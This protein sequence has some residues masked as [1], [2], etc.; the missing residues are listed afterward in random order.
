MRKVL[1]ALTVLF[2]AGPAQADSTT[3]AS[4][5]IFSAGQ[6]SAVCYIAN[7]GPGAV[8]VSNVAI[9]NQN[10]VAQ[11]LI[12]NTCGVALAGNGKVCDFFSAIPANNAFSCSVSVDPSAQFVRGG[13]ELRTATQKSLAN[14]TLQ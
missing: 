11:V 13:F 4:G 12:G 14:A 5:P 2:W 7:F 3:L 8:T 10:G 9:K 6:A 1:L